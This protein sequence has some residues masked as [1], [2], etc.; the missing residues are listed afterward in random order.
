VSIKRKKRASRP[1]SP[2]NLLDDPDM[3]FKFEFLAPLVHQGTLEPLPSLL[4][5]APATMEQFLVDLIDDELLVLFKSAGADLFDPTHS[6]KFSSREARTILQS[7]A[8]RID[9]ELYVATT[10]EADEIFH[11]GNVRRLLEYVRGERDVRSPRRA[12][13]A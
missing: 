2:W 1:D 13:D 12:A 9:Y 11:E 10:A 3:R 5:N 6:R 8:G 7:G 4:E